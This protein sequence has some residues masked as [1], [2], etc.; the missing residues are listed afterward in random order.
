MVVEAEDGLLTLPDGRRVAL[1]PRMFTLPDG[2]RVALKPRMFNDLFVELPEGE[3]TETEVDEVE[4]ATTLE[5][6]REWVTRVCV[7]VGNANRRGGADESLLAAMNIMR[8]RA[9]AR[10]HVLPGIDWSTYE[11]EGEALDEADVEVLELWSGDPSEALH[12]LQRV[13]EVISE[14]VAG[15]P[16][17]APE[18]LAEWLAIFLA[19]SRTFDAER[20]DEL[21]RLTIELA[22]EHRHRRLADEA[23][24]SLQDRLRAVHADVVQTTGV[25]VIEEQG[26]TF[27]RLPA[28]PPSHPSG[29]CEECICYHP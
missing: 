24:D 8:E 21:Q 22:E 5:M 17:V 25:E 6:L 15:N 14:L 23:V 28:R 29:W 26:Q 2:R 16:V 11:P 3:P 10:G 7:L 1:K 20:A 19:T 18:K 9:I 12:E 4:A 27:D 13:Q